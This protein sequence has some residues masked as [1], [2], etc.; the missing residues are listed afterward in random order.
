LFSLAIFRAPWR[1]VGAALLLFSAAV[2]QNQKLPDVMISRDL[3]NVGV[4]LD[5]NGPALALLSK[6]RDQFTVDAWLR[7]L[8]SRQDARDQALIPQCNK[9]PCQVTT[10]GGQVLTIID[11]AFHLPSACR[12]STLV[13][14]RAP[15]STVDHEQC[16]ARLI[17][18]DRS[19]QHPA[20][21]LRWEKG[22]WSE[23]S[24]TR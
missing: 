13:V 3:R 4:R 15:A 7:V 21:F 6:R 8:A 20:M 19:G 23:E 24:A 9:G 1:L 10:E 16:R 17:A 22:T 12:S 2:G 5:G 11:E 18:L 14:M